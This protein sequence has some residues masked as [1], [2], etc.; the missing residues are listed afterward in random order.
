M[1]FD[2]QSWIGQAKAR[3]VQL[4]QQRTA[5][6]TEISK[7]KRILG[8]VTPLTE[9]STA[10]EGPDAGI[11]ESMR[12]IFRTDARLWGATA[13][14]D[15][16]INRGIAMNQQNPMATIHQVL[17]RLE[18]E[19]LIRRVDVAGKAKYQ[20]TLVVSESKSD[21]RQEVTVSASK[22]KA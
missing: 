6:D 13:I 19:G 9:E 10:W 16:L 3:L 21:K 14:R 5:I 12:Q 15:E 11:T 20:S 22:R 4:E 18:K 17:A 1:A 8:E 7:L 2:Y